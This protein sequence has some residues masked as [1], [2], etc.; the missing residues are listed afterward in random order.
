MNGWAD[1]E[2]AKIQNM[3]DRVWEHKSKIKKAIFDARGSAILEIIRQEQASALA[4]ADEIEW[5]VGPPKSVAE[6]EELL[7]EFGNIYTQIGRQYVLPR[8]IPRRINH[9]QRTR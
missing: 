1:E 2:H 6:C 8:K 4:R 9:E 3:C 5:L 7:L